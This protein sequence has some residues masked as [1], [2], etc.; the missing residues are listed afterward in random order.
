MRSLQLRSIL[1]SFMGPMRH[2]LLLLVGCSLSSGGEERTEGIKD[3]RVATQ[4]V[5]TAGEAAPPVVPG[6]S[7][8]GAMVTP[9]YN[10]T[11][12]LLPS[13]K[14]LV[15]GGWHSDGHL[16]SAEV[17][18]PAT[19]A[20]SPTGGLAVPRSSHT[21]TLL[22]SGKVL[23]AGG[24]GPRYEPLASAEVYDPAS[25]SWTFTGELA[26]AR[27]S[28]T[29]TLLP[30]GK[31][32]VTGGV[33]SANEY[34]A[35]AEVY[36]PA[37]GAW[38]P[39]DALATA[40]AGHSATL[41]L[42]GKVLVTG[43]YFD[44]AEVYDPTTGAWSPTGSRNGN[45]FVYSA[46]LLLSGKVLVTQRAE[47]YDPATGAWSPTG[48]L[49]TSRP[50]HSATLLPSGKVLVAGGDQSAEVY[51]PAT[52]A[53]SPAGALS[54]AFFGHT[55]TL[56]PSGNV[57]VAGGST[58]S[59]G[60]FPAR[61]EVYS[62]LIVRAPAL[63]S[64]ISSRTPTYSGVTVANTTVTLLVDDSSVGNAVADAAGSWSLTPATALADGPHTVRATAKNALGNALAE[65]SPVTFMVDATP[66]TAPAVVA[67]ANGSITGDNTPIYSGTAEVGSTVTLLVDDS[68]LGD[69]EADA[70]GNWNFT[71]TTALADGQRT[72]R[73]TATD[74]LGNISVPSSA[75]SFWVDTTWPVAPVVVAPA[76]GLTMG[77]NRPTYN[78]IAEAGS[79][80]NVVVDLSSVGKTTVDAA[81]N[82]SFK[83]TIALA[84]GRRTV[85]ATATD[86][87]GNVS[88][89]SVA[90]SFEIDTMPPRAPVLSLLETFN[91]QKP[92]IA[93][94]AEPYA[95]IRI[96]LDGKEGGETA[97]S[98]TGLWI[99]SPDTE[100]AEGPHQVKA[101]ATDVVGN[102]SSDSQELSFTIVITRK[103]RYGWN[104]ATAPAFPATWALL[105]LS[106]VL[107]GRWLRSRSGA[108]SG[109]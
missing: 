12:T 68:P 80:V 2:L 81:G 71:T 74:S 17:Y 26:T 31:V 16:N 55:A 50:S 61:A 23:V 32:L 38:S 106:L 65:S 4:R 56:L 76:N 98:P 89:N 35:S 7:F 25:G 94:T 51:D 103:S 21:A 8:T 9:R 105:A 78:G 54:T 43:G 97:V 91:T 58:I 39:T 107:R 42:S 96:W 15:A 41:L 48:A 20:W 29:A 85:R 28:H 59:G 92:V 73:A 44:S 46:T 102:V 109:S 86:V 75:N 67:P 37:T 5:E 57:L 3:W 108:R 62:A 18:D 10:H 11:A 19:G 22:P 6:W 40:R 52:R 53:W 63:D 77:N 83:P 34:F 69:V 64:T 90:S 24:Y 72:V 84:D 45:R 82:W 1:A 79:T 100:L 14:V 66:P 33:G 101:T 88:P 93:G 13:G 99:F 70:A 27:I 49:A 30:S 95:S 87:A 47:V 60:F 104:C 36:D